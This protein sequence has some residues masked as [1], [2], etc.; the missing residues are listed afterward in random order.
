MSVYEFKVVPVPRTKSA[1][2]FFDDK[3]AMSLTDAVNA[4]AEDGWTFMR[5]DVLP[6]PSRSR[7]L[8]NMKTRREVLVFRRPVG[9]NP[10]P[11]LGTE[12]RTNMRRSEL[13]RDMSDML[14]GMTPL[15]AVRTA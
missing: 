5:S 12:R 13:V 6:V 1:A 10:Q 8:P 4:L 11:A 14:D 7:F 3:D 15:A 2:R 9:A